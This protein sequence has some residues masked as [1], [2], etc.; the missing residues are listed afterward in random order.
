[1][2]YWVQYMQVAAWP[3]HTDKLIDGCGDR[4]VY[5]LDGRNNMHTMHQDALKFA[6]RHEHW[7]KWAAYRICMG[8]RL[9]EE[10]RSTPVVRISYPVQI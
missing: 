2:K 1:M 6:Q 5:V 9:F 3:L 4:S 8:P 7:H 10:T